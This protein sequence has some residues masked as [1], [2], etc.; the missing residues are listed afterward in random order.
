MIV[1]KITNTVN[2]K[3]YIGKTI[4]TLQR[5]W[6]EHLRASN[7]MPIS[8]AIR[9]Y[10]VDN[11]TIE[12]VVCAISEGVLD[13]LE[14][15]FISELRANDPAV[16]YN[17]TEG[18]DGFPGHTG[19]PHTSESRRK[20]SQACQG[21]KRS[22]S[23]RRKIAASRTGKPLSVETRTKISKN[24]TGLK[25][26]LYGKRHSSETIEKMRLSALARW[27]RG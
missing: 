9:K 18:G 1:Y 11:F 3:V 17:V 19:R 20:I 25:H 13:A 4:R 2:G 10:G 23:T 27:N 22:E 5:R 6:Q 8:R 7:D 24:K 14:K 12:V 16:G 26:P 15:Q 21:L